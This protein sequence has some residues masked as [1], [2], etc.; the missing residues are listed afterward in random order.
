MARSVAAAFA[1]VRV[2]VLDRA[3][4]TPLGSNLGLSSGLG[5]GPHWVRSVVELWVVLREKSW[6]AAVLRRWWVEAQ[7]V[8]LSAMNPAGPGH[9]L[10]LQRLGNRE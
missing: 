3:M 7:S 9:H 4:E 6:I 1:T 8:S 2:G 5:W 10:F